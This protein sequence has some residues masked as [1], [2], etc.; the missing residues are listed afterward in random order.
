MSVG[1]VPTCAS[2]VSGTDKSC[3]PYNIFGYYPGGISGAS[4]A[5]LNGVGI[6][7]GS[8]TEQVYTASITGDL[9]KYGLKSAWATKPVSVN[10]GVEYRD[11]NLQTQFDAAIQGGD[12]AGS[13][14]SSKN[15]S[16]SQADK[17]VFGE[18]SIPLVQDMPF[19]KDITLDAGYRYSDYTSGGGNST[20]KAELDWQTTP[21]L[22]IRGSYERAVR[23][24]NVDELF[25]PA[26]PGLTAGSDPCA[27]SSPVLSAAQC[28]HTFTNSMPGITLAQYTG[29]GY[30][31]TPPGGG[32]STVLGPLYGNT[33]QCPAA[34]C[35]SYGG[36][37][38]NL[39]PE[40]AD[41][42]S[43]GVVFTPTFFRG[44]SLTVDYFNIDVKQA[45][46]GEPSETMLTNCA[47]L[48]NAFDCSNL[49]RF[50]GAGFGVYGGVASEPS[51][52]VFVNGGLI[53]QTLINAAALKT[54][55]VDVEAQYHFRLADYGMGDMGSLTFLF[56]GTAL[57]DL[58]TVLPDG[59]QF[60]CA[61]LYGV[62]CGTPSPKWRHTSTW[63]R[64][65]ASTTST[66]SARASTTSSTRPRR[67][68]MRTASVS[69]L[70][71]L[72]TATP[73]RRSMIRWA[74]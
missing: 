9:G 26:T 23:A 71:P 67:C 35:G 34:Q 60:D 64:R 68:S 28:I 70:R 56:N 12:L 49:Y 27:G 41:T 40:T 47:T 48:N 61:G 21:D 19:A 16:G 50:Q 36:G 42:F 43:Y 62:T 45:I 54:S 29:G 2:V 55:G 31:Y 24:P 3:V 52:G 58:I 13:G 39:K 74:V 14:G 11:E 44:F 20:Y 32:P 4:L 38:P 37:N 53:N 25:T 10:L 30:V 18:L 51:P 65:T 59:T 72:G 63:P 6:S 22:M 8:T 5:Y 1:G 73:T 69:R 66:R 17:D 57:H 15:T 46:V 33:N 7:S